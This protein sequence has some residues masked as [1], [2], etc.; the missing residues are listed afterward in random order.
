MAVNKR[1]FYQE[2][3]KA[4]KKGQID[5]AISILSQLVETDPNEVKAMHDLIRLYSKKGDK[6]KVVDVS[7]ELS[8]RHMNAGFYPKAL[9]IL[10]N[11]LSVDRKNIDTYK[12]LIEV[13]QNL[14]Y[15]GELVNTIKDAVVVLD[16]EGRI[17]EE[18]E[19]LKKLIEIDPDNVAARFKLAEL[20]LQQ[21][22]KEAA[23]KEFQSLIATLEKAGKY[24]EMAILLEKKIKIGLDDFSTREKLA[25][26]YV[27]IKDYLKALKVLQTFVEKNRVNERVMW[28]MAESLEGVNKPDKALHVLKQL[29]KLYRSRGD[30]ERIERVARWITKIA[31]D[32]HDARTLL[33]ETQVREIQEKE[34]REETRAEVVEQEERVKKLINKFLVSV[35]YGLTSTA[36]SVLEEILTLLDDVDALR[37]YARMCAKFRFQE[38]AEKLFAKAIELAGDNSRVKEA[39]IEEVKSLLPNSPLAGQAEVEEEIPLEEE[40]EEVVLT[41]SAETLEESAPEKAPVEE[42]EEEEEIT[43]DL[44]EEEISV[45][46]GSETQVEIKETA[47]DISEESIEMEEEAGEEEEIEVDLG[48]EEPATEDIE[49]EEEEVEAAVSFSDG[50]EAFEEEA[51]LDTDRGSYEEEMVTEEDIMEAFQSDDVDIEEELGDHDIEEQPAS[52]EPPEE[53]EIRADDSITLEDDISEAEFYM[54]QGLYDEAKEVLTRV[55]ERRPNSE[56]ARI[57]MQ[58]IEEMEKATEAQAE[59]KEEDIVIAGESNAPEFEESI[60][61]GDWDLKEVLDEQLEGEEQPAQAAPAEPTHQVSAE[62]VLQEFKKG[63]KKILGEEEGQAHYD[64]GLAYV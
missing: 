26:C 19:F 39:I 22:D 25:E 31:P 49:V 35:K 47:P 18:M 20:Y 64:L 9:G 29:L 55:L 45:D 63:V 4:E 28:L 56:K 24:K 52:S 8:R 30:K 37:N 5:K 23:D 61:E 62:E 41:T 40:E 42:E 58:R 34:T 54:N 57:L 2:A 48:S 32:D 13:Y 60:L 11:A 15:K 38:G 50:S 46:M 43:V 44:G 33:G 21:G 1:Q 27:R 12:Q 6:K 17:D 53:E 51:E 59:V 16:E 10:K 3:L 14:N 7:I 36:R